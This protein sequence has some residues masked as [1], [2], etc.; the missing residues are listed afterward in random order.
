MVSQWPGAIPYDPAGPCVS[1]EG[2]YQGHDVWL[3]F[4]AEPPADEEPG[5]R[6]SAGAPL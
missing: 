4:L 6:L 3:R 5:L 2:L 1:I